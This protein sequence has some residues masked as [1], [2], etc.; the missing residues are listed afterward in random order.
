MKAYILTEADFEK[1]LLMVDRDPKHG[2]T[3]GSSDASVRDRENAQ[4][5]EKAH[6]FYNYQV[7]TWIDQV[8]S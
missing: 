3:G 1:L 6:R 4:A 8:K 5:H 2:Q 7:R